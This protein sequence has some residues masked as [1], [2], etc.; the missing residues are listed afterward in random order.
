MNT[1]NYTANL[2][3]LAALLEEQS[4]PYQFIAETA[5][6]LQGVP[7]ELGKILVEVQWDLIENVHDHVKSYNP[8]PLE[9]DQSSGRFQF[10]M[11]GINVEVLCKYNTALRTDPYRIQVKHEGSTYWCR[12]FYSEMSPPSKFT[13]LVR[14][15][16]GHQQRGITEQ[17]ESAWNQNNYQALINRYG[18]PDQVAEK[19]KRNPEARIGAFYSYMDPVEGKRIAHLM[20]SNGIKAAGLSLLGAEVTVVDFSQENAAYAGEVADATGITIDYIVSDV[21]SLEAEG[22]FDIVLMELGVLHYF[23]DLKPLMQKITSLLRPGGKFVL[24]EFHPISTKLITS[25]GKK[26]KVTGN[27]FDPTIQSRQVAFTKYAS[28]GDTPITNVLQRKW[29]LG[30]LI[31]AVAAEGLAIKVLEEEPNQKT[32]DFGLPKTFTLV[33]QK[34]I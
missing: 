10:G 9:R 2:Y 22:D 33:A 24:H 6:F 12:S 30:E 1:M 4:I 14:E 15:H 31:T 23:I 8:T 17:N 16:L 5:L 18:T 21:L 34:I 27:Y 28:N 13:N 29:T 26:H 7:V 11:N 20:G 25:N 19:I 3:N 32:H